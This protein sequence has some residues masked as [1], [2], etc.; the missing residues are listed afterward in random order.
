VT[1]IPKLTAEDVL[2]RYNEEELPNFLEIDLKDV[3]QANS[4]GRGASAAA[5]TAFA[6]GA[7]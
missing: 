4:A 3:N 7:E 5:I 6:L 2:R 1:N